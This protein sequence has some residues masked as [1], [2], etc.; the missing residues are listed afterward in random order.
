MNQTFALRC[1]TCLSKVNNDKLI[2]DNKI[3][4]VRALV[5][6]L[7]VHTPLASVD[8]ETGFDPHHDISVW[9]L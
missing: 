3:P 5:W 8:V 9:S 6:Y 7:S 2:P 1:A 4:Y